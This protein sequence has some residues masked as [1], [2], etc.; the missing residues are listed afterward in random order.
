MRFALIDETGGAT[1]LDGAALTPATLSAIASA[2]QI[3]LNRDLAPETGGGPFLV[4]VSDGKDLQPG[5]V[6][7]AILP[8]LPNAPGAI[9]YHD[10]NGQGVPVAYDA[11]TLSNSLTGPGNS[12]SVAIS[13]ELCETAGDPGCNRWADRGDG[14]EV[15]LEECDAVE[16]QT[17][18]HG[19]ASTPAQSTGIYVSNFVLRS[20]WQ[21]HAPP[22]YD[23]MTSRGIAGGAGPSGP[24]QTA[25]AGGGDYQIVR[26]T[27]PQSEGQ[28]TAMGAPTVTVSVSVPFGAR[29][30]R[31]WRHGSRRARRGVPA[32]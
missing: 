31:P 12:L 11:I 32:A 22:P 29:L 21:P 2:C 24:M 16:S 19:A 4:R 1:T 8:T 14:T 13:H 27:N 3:Q 15:A 28:V 6:A 10:V 30:R 20:F 7:F 5:E 25:P 18:D 23:F 17:Y 9:A 26:Q